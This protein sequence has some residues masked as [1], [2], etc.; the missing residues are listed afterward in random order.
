MFGNCQSYREAHDE[1]QYYLGQDQLK[2]L[3]AEVT[4][5][6]DQGYTWNS[7]YTQCTL[8]NILLAYRTNTAYDPNFCLS[9]DRKEKLEYEVELTAETLALLKKYFDEYYD[10][11]EDDG[12]AIA[13]YEDVVAPLQKKDEFVDVHK[14]LK[15]HKRDPLYSSEEIEDTPADYEDLL[16]KLTPA[17]LELLA[18]Y[19]GVDEEE[20]TA[21]VPDVVYPDYGEYNNGNE[22]YDDGL[23]ES[24]YDYSDG[25]EGYDESN[26]A[27]IERL[28]GTG[29]EDYGPGEVA[30]DEWSDEPTGKMETISLM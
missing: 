13:D 15:S 30:D 20:E 2:L 21:E 11:S 17:D 5:L 29:E 19:L 4:S 23:R 10:Y 18:D 1:Y 14:Y 28:M 6:L 22:L 8:G 24:E 3:E 16:R 7:L 9:E 25:K 26:E 12:N 27:A